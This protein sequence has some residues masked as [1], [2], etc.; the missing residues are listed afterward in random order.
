MSNPPAKPQSNLRETIMSNPNIAGNMKNAMPIQHRRTSFDDISEDAESELNYHGNME[1]HNAGISSKN[2]NN[3]PKVKIADNTSKSSTTKIK[4]EKKKIGPAA[5]RK[6]HFDKK[7]EK[8][9]GHRKNSIHYADAHQDHNYHHFHCHYN[10]ANIRIHEG[11]RRRRL[12]MSNDL[13]DVC[14]CLSSALDSLR[15]EVLVARPLDPKRNYIEANKKTSYAAEELGLGYEE[16]ERIKRLMD[17]C[18]NLDITR[19]GQI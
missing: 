9:S 4:K 13:Y 1:S 12:E 2:S 11:N 3:Q 16:N 10:S 17:D 18:D 8:K 15:F 19:T 5:E 7:A 14:K 6:T